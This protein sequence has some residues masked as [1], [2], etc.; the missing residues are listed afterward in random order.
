[1]NGVYKLQPGLNTVRILPPVQGKRRSHFTRVGF[2]TVECK[3]PCSYCIALMLWEF[4]ANERAGTKAFRE[5][6]D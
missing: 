1:M 3:H 5:G 2:N 6:A 4:E